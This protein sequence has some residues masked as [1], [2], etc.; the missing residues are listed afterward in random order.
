[1]NDHRVCSDRRR[2][3]YGPPSGCAERRVCADRRLPVIE[4]LD[5]SSDEFARMFGG[6]TKISDADYPLDAAAQKR[7]LREH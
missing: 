2:R 1:M 5:L 3:D 6:T 4:E 7:R